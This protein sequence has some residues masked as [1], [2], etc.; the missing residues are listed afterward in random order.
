M[1][2]RL[3][4]RNDGV[5]WGIFKERLKLNNITA[6]LR[7]TNAHSVI[8]CRLIKKINNVNKYRIQEEKLTQT[9][10]LMSLS[11]KETYVVHIFFAPQNAE[12]M[13]NCR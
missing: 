6:V 12:I 1:I 13:D 11:K 3:T 10:L 2:L 7:K 8:I 9:S 5:W 4:G